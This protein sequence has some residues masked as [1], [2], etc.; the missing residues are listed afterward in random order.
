MSAAAANPPRHPK[1]RAEILADALL[2]D[3]GRHERRPFRTEDYENAREGTYMTD[4]EEKVMRFDRVV[5]IFNHL[6]NK[7]LLKSGLPVWLDDEGRSIPV[8]FADVLLNSLSI[9]D[10]TVNP[11]DYRRALDVQYMRTD[12]ENT[13][14]DRDRFKEVGIETAVDEIRNGLVEFLNVRLDLDTEPGVSGGSP[15]T[16]PGT[17]GWAKPIGASQPSPAVWAAGEK[18]EVP[19]S[20]GAAARKDSAIVGAPYL[21][22]EVNTKTVDIDVE[23]APAWF[24]SW[25]LFGGPTTPTEGW[26]LPGLYRFRGRDDAGRYRFDAAKFRIPPLQS[27]STIL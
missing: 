22:F 16:G 25:N 24:L 1:S 13:A 27:A 3:I 5:R 6:G 10:G 14:F 2:L 26:I 4:V 20:L 9:G 23:Q 21:P 17:Q 11:T 8:D 18:R 19:R 7:S 15:L 12:M